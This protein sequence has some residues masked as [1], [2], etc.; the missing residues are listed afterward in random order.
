MDEVE[1][2]REVEHGHGDRGPGEEAARQLWGSSMRTA[3][4]A[5]EHR[6][7]VEDRVGEGHASASDG[8]SRRLV[9]HDR[10]SQEEAMRN[11]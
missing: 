1:D 10:T 3:L 5:L 6:L 9:E 7:P 8:G 2:R 4:H 11:G